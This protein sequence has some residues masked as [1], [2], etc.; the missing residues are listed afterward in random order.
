MGSEMC[1]RDSNRTDGN[2]SCQTLYDTGPWLLLSLPKDRHTYLSV[3]DL[4]ISKEKREGSHR[5]DIYIVMK[6][7][8]LC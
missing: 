8:Y 6:Y 1:I 7:M 3:L 5:D 2:S 4:T